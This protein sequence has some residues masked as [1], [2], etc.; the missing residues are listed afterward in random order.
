[1]FIILK[2][3]ADRTIKRHR[4]TYADEIVATLRKRYAQGNPRG[5][6]Q[7]LSAPPPAVQG[8]PGAPADLSLM[9]EEQGDVGLNGELPG[10]HRQPD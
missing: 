2:N 4:V 5:Q 1:M 7:R 8:L 9:V 6:R 10:P 3:F